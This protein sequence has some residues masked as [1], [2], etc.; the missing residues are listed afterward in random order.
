MGWG[1]FGLAKSGA[2]MMNLHMGAK[3]WKAI[4]SF[5]DSLVWRSSLLFNGF[6]VFSWFQIGNHL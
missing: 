4:R 3:D 2:V 6:L 1:K 5:Q